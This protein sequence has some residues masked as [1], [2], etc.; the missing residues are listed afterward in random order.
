MSEKDT[1]MNAVSLQNLVNESTSMNVADTYNQEGLGD[2]A[3]MMNPRHCDVPVQEEVKPEE[4]EAE[5]YERVTGV[6]KRKGFDKRMATKNW[7][8]KKFYELAN[9]DNFWIEGRIVMVD[10]KTGKRYE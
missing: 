5:K 7:L 1:I 8:I 6:E 4:I 10:R 2:L 9:H 3:Y